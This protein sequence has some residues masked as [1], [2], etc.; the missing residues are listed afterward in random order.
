MGNSSSSLKS[1]K[2]NSLPSSPDVKRYISLLLR[3]PSTAEEVPSQRQYLNACEHGSNDTNESFDIFFSCNSYRQKQLPVLYG[4]STVNGGATSIPLPQTVSVTRRCP[5]D[6]IR[7][8]PPTPDQSQSKC[9]SL[10]LHMSMSVC[11][12][13]AMPWLCVIIRAV[14]RFNA[15]YVSTPT[16]CLRFAQTASALY[17]DIRHRT[18][19]H[20]ESCV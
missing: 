11:Y 5:P 3:T 17:N 16:M 10:P 2:C 7:P 15:V 8:L 19:T 4:K 13:L 1:R 12:I 20:I 14:Y 6:K 9:W 18:R